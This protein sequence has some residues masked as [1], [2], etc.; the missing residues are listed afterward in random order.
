MDEW[1]RQRNIEFNE[2]KRAK[3]TEEVEKRLK[4]DVEV[5]QEVSDDF[6]EWSGRGYISTTRGQ[7]N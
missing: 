6:Q 3:R 1:T 7:E 4:G 2:R 5:S